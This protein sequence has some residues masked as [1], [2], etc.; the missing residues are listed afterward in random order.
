MPL[1]GLVLK[2]ISLDIILDIVLSFSRDVTHAMSGQPKRLSRNYPATRNCG[3][4]GEKSFYMFHST[5]IFCTLSRLFVVS[6][7]FLLS[8]L[9]KLTSVI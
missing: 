2:V 6:V 4:C 7:V 5:D 9:L 3:N 1:K 8:L